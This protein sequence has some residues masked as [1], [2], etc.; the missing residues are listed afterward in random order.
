MFNNRGAT[1]YPI[2]AVDV[3]HTFNLLD[4]WPMYM[5]TNCA[6]Q[7]QFAHMVNH[8]IFKVKNEV[9]G[10]FYLAFCIAGL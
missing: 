9:D 4:H 8:R 1:V 2:A 3:L 6:I 7:T 10:G 5:A